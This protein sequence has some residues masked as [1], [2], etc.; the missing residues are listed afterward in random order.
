MCLW[1]EKSL[2]TQHFSN[3]NTME[4]KNLTLFFPLNLKACVELM[5]SSSFIHCSS[6]CWV[7]RPFRLSDNPGFCLVNGD[8][9]RKCF[10]ADVNTM[11]LH[12]E[13][14]CGIWIKDSLLWLMEKYKWQFE[15]D[16]IGGFVNYSDY[17]IG[18][19]RGKWDIVKSMIWNTMQI[20]SEM[21]E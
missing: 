13:H 7:V 3:K 2:E 20:E 14:R 11:D 16:R 4:F 8:Y 6:R 18:V 19:R 21:K 10:W 15:V 12:R 9:V 5:N 17:T 1:K